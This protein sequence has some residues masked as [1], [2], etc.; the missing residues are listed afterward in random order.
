MN[1]SR[2]ESEVFDASSPLREDRARELGKWSQEQA[3][4]TAGEEG[5]T[6]TD[7][8]WCVID[9]LRDYYLEKGLAQSAR[10]L[11]DMLNEEFSNKGGSRYLYQLFPKGPVSQGMRIAGLRLPAYTE[12]TG[13][14]SSV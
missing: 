1:I 5:I 10:E 2:S 8:H 6:L 7:E 13:F 12:D 11:S 3:I 4:R 9:C 14:G